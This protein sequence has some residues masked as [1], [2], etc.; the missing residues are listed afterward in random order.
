MDQET[1]ERVLQQQKSARQVFETSPQ[2]FNSYS[3]LSHTYTTKRQH[4]DIIRA[5]IAINH[6]GGYIV[7]FK[8]ETGNG[9]VYRT[10]KEPDLKQNILN[11]VITLTEPETQTTT[12][13][14][15]NCTTITKN[16]INRIKPY[17]WIQDQTERAKFAQYYATRVYSKNDEVLSLYRLPPTEYEPELVREF[18]EFY[19]SRVFNIRSLHEELASHAHRFRNPEVFIEKCFIHYS[20]EG[21]TGKSLLSAALALMY[22]TDAASFA[23]VAIVPNQLENDRFNNYSKSRCCMLRRPKPQIISGI[24]WMP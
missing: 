5:F 24:I 4:M 17:K 6:N 11:S 2:T 19:E 1:V 15:G 16:K 20:A 8:N 9:W 22:K 3:M 23:N 12:D 7:K 13:P 21:N 10:V 14:D 18:I